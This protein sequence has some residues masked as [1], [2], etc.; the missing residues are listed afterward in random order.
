MFSEQQCGFM[1]GKEKTL[2]EKYR[3]GQKEFQCVSVDSERI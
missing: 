3:E 2:M 1:P